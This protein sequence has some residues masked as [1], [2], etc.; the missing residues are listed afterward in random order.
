MLL[1]QSLQTST[2]FADSPQVQL[3]EPF[4]SVFCFACV[5]TS[6]KTRS[7]LKYTQWAQILNLDKVADQH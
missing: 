1:S 3:A 7:Q 2:V 4:L 6:G 5:M